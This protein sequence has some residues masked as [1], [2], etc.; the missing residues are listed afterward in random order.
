MQRAD[1]FKGLFC[2][3]GAAFSS[4]ALAQASPDAVLLSQAAAKAEQQLRQSFINLQFDDFRLSPVRGPL[5]QANA[6]GRMV[7]YAPES[8]NVLFAAIYDRNGVNLTSLEQDAA[9]RKRLASLDRSQA[10]VMGPPDAP[11]VVEFTDPDCPYCRALDR[12]WATKAAEG[13]PVRRHIFFV[14]GIHPQAEA[15]AEHI[16][17]A[18]DPESAFRSIYSGATPETLTKCESGHARVSAHGKAVAQVGVSGTPTLILDGKILSGF[19]QAEIEAF[20][21]GRKARDRASR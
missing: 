9:A 10:L 7:Y 6:G 14:T 1:P 17:C 8:D 19:Q 16:L 2:L 18:A 5:Y 12:Y 21:D 15:K 20:L 13:K 3:F 4:I 11:D